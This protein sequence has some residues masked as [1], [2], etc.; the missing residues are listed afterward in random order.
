[1]RNHLAL[2]AILGTSFA[3]AQ[4]PWVRTTVLSCA[5]F[6]ESTDHHGRPVYAFLLFYANDSV[7]TVWMADYETAYNYDHSLKPKELLASFV[8]EYHCEASS[9]DW[10]DGVTV[11]W[12]AGASVVSQDRYYTVARFENDG[13]DF[14]LGNERFTLMKCWNRIVHPKRKPT[15]WR[16]CEG[17]E[18]E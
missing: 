8:E 15:R 13:A 16:R 18:L 11:D 2:A 17:E 1:M 9:F 6:Q 5:Y 10:D 4:L 3:Q 12:F 14:V 7:V